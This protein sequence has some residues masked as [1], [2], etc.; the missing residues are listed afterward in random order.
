MNLARVTMQNRPASNTPASGVRAGG[1]LLEDG[2]AADPV[3]LLPVIMIAANS[4]GNQQIRG[5]GYN[6][7]ATLQLNYTLNNVPRVGQSYY[8]T[9]PRMPREPSRTV[10]NRLSSGPTGESQDRPPLT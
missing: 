8:A 2:A 4:V 6:D 10:R 3:S 1:S 5:V 9:N 7:A